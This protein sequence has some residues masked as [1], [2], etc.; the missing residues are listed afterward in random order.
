MARILLLLTFVGLVAA[1]QSI[2]G[3]GYCNFRQGQGG[4]EIQAQSSDNVANAAGC[5]TFC[6]TH[7]MTKYNKYAEW[8][9]DL[10]SCFCQSTCPCI[11]GPDELFAGSRVQM[12]P[13]SETVPSTCSSDSSGSISTNGANCYQ[14]ESKLSMGSCGS[15]TMKMGICADTEAQAN[16][17]WEF[18]SGI[19][20]LAGLF[21]DSSTCTQSY[22]ESCDELNLEVKASGCDTLCA[23]IKASL[24]MSEAGGCSSNDQCPMTATPKK[25]CCED[26]A[27]VAKDMCKMTD[28]QKKT[29]KEAAKAAGDCADTDCISASPAAPHHTPSVLFSLFLAVGVLLMR[30]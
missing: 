24:K 19:M 11:T 2:T 27:N 18:Q 4:E 12:I 16:E 1:Q 26:M 7:N 15:M 22:K 9:G 14:K 13:T 10:N 17:A 5:W 8:V 6:S 20:Q 23:Q 30:Y 28:D 21:M 29:I 3:K 25:M